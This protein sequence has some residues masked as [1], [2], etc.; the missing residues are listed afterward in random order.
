VHSV[1]YA[2]Q[3]DL[4]VAITFEQVFLASTLSVYC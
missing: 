1:N 3:A 2:I 4:F